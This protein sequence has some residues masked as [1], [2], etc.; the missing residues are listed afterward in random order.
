M[1]QEVTATLEVVGETEDLMAFLDERESN[2]GTDKGMELVPDE[3]IP[4]APEDD[5]ALLVPDD[6]PPY[7]AHLEAPESWLIDYFGAIARP[8]A[9]P[10]ITV[11][12]ETAG[13]KMFVTVNVDEHRRPFEVFLRIG[14]AGEVEYAHL[15]GLG[16]MISYCLRIG[17]DP[18]GVIDHLKGIT[19]EPVWYKGELIRSAE[20]GVSYVLRRIMSGYYDDLIDRVVYRAEARNRTATQGD[21]SRKV[22][23]DVNPRAGVSVHAER[24]R[25]E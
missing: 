10:G 9:A 23:P 3:D 25:E 15:E 11:E 2:M 22:L 20:D 13:G 18:E 16:R 1:L 12:V 14:K 19:S 5:L 8:A 4:L 6:E 17:G 21:S 24:V 7:D